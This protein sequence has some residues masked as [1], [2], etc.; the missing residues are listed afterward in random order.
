MVWAHSPGGRS[1]EAEAAPVKIARRLG[2]FWLHAWTVAGLTPAVLRAFCLHLPILSGWATRRWSLRLLA[3]GDS[4][5]FEAA[6]QA[7]F[8]QWRPED[9]TPK[10][11]FYGRDGWRSFVSEPDYPSP[12]GS[13]TLHLASRAFFKTIS[14]K[15]GLE[16]LTVEIA[17]LGPGEC[18]LIYAP[19]RFA[20][21][22]EEFAWVPQ[23][24]KFAALAK[25]TPGMR[26]L[27]FNPSFDRNG[28]FHVVIKHEK[29]APSAPAPTT[30]ALTHGGHYFYLNAGRSRL[31]GN[32]A[33][34]L[35]A[36]GLR[37]LERRI[38]PV[39]EHSFLAR[40][41]EDIAV[42]PGQI[43]MGHY[44][45]WVTGARAGGAL[46]ILYG[47]GDRFRPER[48]DAPF[49][50]EIQAQ[51]DFA[52][53][54]T[55][56]HLVV[57]QAGG[58]WRMTDPFPYPGLCRWMDLPVSPAVFPRTKKRIAAPGKRVFCFIG[59]YDDYQK[60]LDIA[61]E[62]CRRCPEMQ[63]I[64]IG[65]KPIGAPNCREYPAVDNR[66]PAFRR[67]AAQA[68][69]IVSPARDDAQ[70]GTIAECGS[71]GL[72]PIISETTGYVLSFPRRLDAN[73]LDQ[74]MMVLKEAQ[75]A[76]ADAIKGWQALNAHYIEQFHRPEVYDALMD[77][78]LR[79]V[80]SERVKKN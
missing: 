12:P 8:E 17:A 62:L 6:R 43:A 14:P 73:D 65:C 74:C 37:A 7:Q 25:R 35:S 44:G 55:A 79:E 77:S 32:S 53:Q 21:G 33:R 2:R 58:R 15:A 13:G 26:I 4:A 39:S 50:L 3:V 31:L 41:P 40:V 48:H 80:V 56:A 66:R 68:D 67:L 75:A 60:G 27:D 78:Y 38:G 34:V 42:G 22:P 9:L 72:L 19:H 30:Q 1:P 59:L 11:F 5:A 20:Y 36:A 76:N 24:E 52:A 69:F 46:T 47:P 57:M 10:L 45:N 63:F 18:L 28:F 29:A 16:R 23:W 70:P 49:F 54:Y 61:Q 64:A 71:L 51:G